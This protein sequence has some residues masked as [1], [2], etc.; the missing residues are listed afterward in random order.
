M[1]LAGAVLGVLVVI[2]VVTGLVMIGAASATS[3]ASS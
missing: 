3:R 2:A 1:V